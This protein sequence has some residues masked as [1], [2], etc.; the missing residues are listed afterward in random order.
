MDNENTEMNEEPTV[1]DMNETDEAARLFF[2][3]GAKR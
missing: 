1:Q 3:G 2:E